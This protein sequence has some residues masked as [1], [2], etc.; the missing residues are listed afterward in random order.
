MCISHSAME[1]QRHN[2]SLNP[3]CFCLQRPK[4]YGA[5][6][7]GVAWHPVLR[8]INFSWRHIGGK[9]G[10]IELFT[11]RV[12][13]RASYRVFEYSA[14]CTCVVQPS[15]G[16]PSKV[17]VRKAVYWRTPDSKGKSS[18]VVFAR[19]TSTL[20][21]HVSEIKLVTRERN[22]VTNC[23]KVDLVVTRRVPADALDRRVEYGST[24]STAGQNRKLN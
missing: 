21:W 2:N 4:K 7:R 3:R 10:R 5:R 16:H 17:T 9:A 14:G 6:Y 12:L 8:R 13:C 1:G 23:Y 20:H 18:F 11:A 15:G 22:Y 19:N 24:H